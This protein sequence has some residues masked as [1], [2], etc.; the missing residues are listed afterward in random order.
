MARFEYRAVTP[1]RADL[2]NDLNAL[3]P[4]E[5]ATLLSEV[6]DGLDLIEVA[7]CH[8]RSVGAELSAAVVPTSLHPDPDRIR[9]L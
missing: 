2:V 8:E 9:R 5:E 6:R 4:D 3:R 7:S 1:N